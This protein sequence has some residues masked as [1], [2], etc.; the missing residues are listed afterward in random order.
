MT[1]LRAVGLSLGYK[2]KRVIEDFNAAIPSG[3]MV[4]LIGPNGSG[5][6]T[7][8][9]ALAGVIKP[10]QGSIHLNGLDLIELSARKRAQ[11]VGWVPQ[12][13]AIAWPLTV[14][15]VVSLGRAPHRGWLLPLTK[16]D[17]E[18]V[19]RVMGLTEMTSLSDRRVDELSAGE[20]QQVLIA[21]ALTQEPQVLLLDEPT[22]NLDVH[23][24]M[25]VMDLVRDLVAH[26]NITAVIA[27][28][29]L[30]LAARYC[31]ELILLHNGWQICAGDPRE[32]LRP[33]NI[34]PVFEVE[35][36]LYHDPWDYLTVSARNGVK[37]DDSRKE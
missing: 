23:H 22:S 24:Q 6:T 4:G 17:E 20:F 25:Q 35:S 18:V 36:C 2:D 3:K 30:S 34:A 8:L 11:L 16:E 5:K 29:D 21:R 1:T 26:Q 28:H 13:E 10:M 12:R 9:R 27:I 31:D 32:V 19:N 15:E 7:L 14:R 33:E 37:K